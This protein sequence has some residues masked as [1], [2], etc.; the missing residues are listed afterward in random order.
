MSMVFVYVHI[1]DT[2]MNNLRMDLAGGSRLGQCLSE[3]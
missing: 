3:M 2:N 1:I